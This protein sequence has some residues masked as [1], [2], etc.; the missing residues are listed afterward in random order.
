MTEINRIFDL[1]EKYKSDYKLKDDVLAGKSDGKWEKF[2]IQD[3]IHHSNYISSALLSLGIKKSDKIATIIPN[4]PYW[5]FIDMG[6]MKI[7]AIHVPIYPT[8]SDKDLSFILEH[9][10]IKVLFV[11]NQEFALKIRIL[12]EKSSL[13]I[14]IF[15]LDSQQEENSIAALI[16]EGKKTLDVKEINSLSKSISGDD[17]ATLIYT[18]GT[19]GDPKGVMLT[20]KN[21]ISNFI[22]VSYIPTFGEEGRALSFLPLC[23]VYERMLNYLY[24]Y[25]G[26]SVYYCENMGT[27]VDNI[28]EVK[29]DMMSAVPRFLEKVYEKIIYKG[30]S[31]KGIKKAI[32]NFALKIASSYETYK[33]NKI[34]FYS[35]QLF[36]ARKLVLNKWRKALGGNFK[37]IV[38]GGAALQ[39]RIAKV[40]WAA[41]IP[42]YE[43]YGLTETSPVIAVTNNDQHGVTFGTV[44][45]ALKDLDVKIT[46][47]GEIICKGP[48]IMSGY[49]KAPELTK[50]VIDAEGYF[51]TGDIGVFNE[52]GHL[53]ITGRKKEIFKTSAGKYIAPQLIE[54]KL[55]ESPFV[56]NVM[57]VGENEKFASALIVPD[58]SYLR[59]WCKKNHIPFAKD[60]DILQNKQIRYRVLREIHDINLELGK[61]ERIQ[62][63]RFCQNVWSI[64]SGE[65]TPTLKLKRDIISNNYK[66]L[67]N[68]IYRK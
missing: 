49:Y 66:Q 34:S 13:D 65:L 36:I 18:S 5:N 24:Q 1:L 38:S 11:K 21:I 32:F 37:I 7:G 20:H 3:Y 41:R 35:I 55:R 4:S 6:V 42:I 10:E 22:G 40:F 50:E 9:A 26:I 27:I 52:K 60:E 46:E 17:I 68:E 14:R 2:T 63:F 39:P 15:H 67:I 29:P 16:E 51:H 54:N 53:K 31:L 44:G 45:S 30:K 58:Y 25:L 47:D 33:E 23:H 62:K 64:E 28:Q 8:S 56:D 19:T 59:N 57:V 12:L 43:G 48:S 61:P